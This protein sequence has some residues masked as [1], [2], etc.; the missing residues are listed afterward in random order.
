MTDPYEEEEKASII[1]HILYA[2]GRFEQLEKIG[3]VGGGSEWLTSKGRERFKKL[4][5]SGFVPHRDKLI[6]AILVNNRCP[7]KQVETIANLM[8][9][10][11]YIMDEMKK[12]HEEG[13]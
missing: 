5:E 3:L 9:D 8:L 1:S 12:N 2:E 4:I 6:K 10:Y 7:L 13:Y 11:D